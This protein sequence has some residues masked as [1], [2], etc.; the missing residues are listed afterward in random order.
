L[1]SNHDAARALNIPKLAHFAKSLGWMATSMEKNSSL[2][3]EE[4]DRIMIDFIDHCPVSSLIIVGMEH[5]YNVIEQLE[6]KGISTIGFKTVA[7]GC[8]LFVLSPK[9]TAGG[10]L[11]LAYYVIQLNTTESGETQWMLQ[12]VMEKKGQTVHTKKCKI[13]EIAI[14][15]LKSKGIDLEIGDSPGKVIRLNNKQIKY[16]HDI[17]SL[18][19]RGTL[20]PDKQLYLPISTLKTNVIQ[21][22]ECA[23]YKKVKIPETVN[24]VLAMLITKLFSPM[25]VQTC[26]L[27]ALSSQHKP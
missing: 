23:C 18:E 16:L 9:A 2:P 24:F 15:D 1:L 27:E 3:D 6:K 10:S 11:Q 14:E 19:N 22:P 8:E 26:K 20:I 5:F 21:A 17:A 7:E 13:P 25:Y 4:R 12:G